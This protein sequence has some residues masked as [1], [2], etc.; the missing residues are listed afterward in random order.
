[1]LPP[2]PKN[3]PK[4]EELYADVVFDEE[5][6][7]H[8]DEDSDDE[9]SRSVPY[10]DIGERRRPMKARRLRKSVYRVRGPENRDQ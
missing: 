9:S 3:D 7:N 2:D 10:A 1:M 4:P 6:F 5:V 8:D